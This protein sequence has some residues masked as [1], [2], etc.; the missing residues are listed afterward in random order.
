MLLRALCNSR[1]GS[2]VQSYLLPDLTDGQT[3]HETVF[4][5]ARELR[6][7]SSVSVAV[8]SQPRCEDSR[9][10][11]FSLGFIS[12]KLGIKAVTIEFNSCGD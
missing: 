11:S 8:S 5:P 1:W 7:L 4:H 10:T 12:S 9:V 6:F 2:T 3:A